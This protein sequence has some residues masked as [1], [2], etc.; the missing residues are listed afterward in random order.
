MNELQRGTLD[1]RYFVTRR[2]AVGPRLL[3]RQVP[4]GRLRPEP[5]ASLAQ[6]ATGTPTLMMLGYFYGPTRRTP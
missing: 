2:L 4:G 1:G 3:V 6:P 5:G